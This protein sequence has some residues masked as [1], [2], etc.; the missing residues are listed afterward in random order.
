MI[1][2]DHLQLEPFVGISSPVERDRAITRVA[3][4][5]I[6]SDPATFAGRAWKKA[7]RFWRPWPDTE[8]YSSRIFVVVSELSIVPLMLFSLFFF[9]RAA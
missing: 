9:V 2:L 5:Y 1:R 6:R 8:S 7:L 4:N 3:I